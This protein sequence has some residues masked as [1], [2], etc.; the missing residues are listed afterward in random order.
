MQSRWMSLVE[1]VANVLVA[2]FASLLIQSGLEF[3][4]SNRA[5]NMLENTEDQKILKGVIGLAEAFGRRV[6]RP[7]QLLVAK[8]NQ[9]LLNLQPRRGQRNSGNQSGC[10]AVS[11]HEP[12]LLLPHHGLARV[13]LPAWTT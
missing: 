4:F 13:G 2:I 12:A 1:S 11:F 10:L 6:I 7:R 9:G 8:S 3:W 5:R